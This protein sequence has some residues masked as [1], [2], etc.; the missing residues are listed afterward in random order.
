PMVAAT[1][2]RRGGGAGNGGGAGVAAAGGWREE[3]RAGPAD[4]AAGRTS[5][6]ES[7]LRTEVMASFEIVL[8]VSNTPT[9]CSAAASKCRDPAGL[10]AA[11]SSSTA[12][13]FRM[14]RL[15]YWKT[16]GI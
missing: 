5:S 16:I 10:S 7:F 8:R 9:P 2:R 1:G 6:P 12:R 14:S 11:C 13:M 15:L 4:E 3:G